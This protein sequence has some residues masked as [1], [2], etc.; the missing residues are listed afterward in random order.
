MTVLSLDFVPLIADAILVDE[1]GRNVCG[2]ESWTRECRGTHEKLQGPG[3]GV[4]LHKIP[5]LS[6][7]RYSEVKSGCRFDMVVTVLVHKMD[8]PIEAM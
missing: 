8:S 3:L 4:L 5:K 7:L 6:L 1:H 2:R